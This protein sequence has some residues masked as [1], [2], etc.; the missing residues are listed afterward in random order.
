MALAETVERQSNAALAFQPGPS[1]V[2]DTVSGAV[3]LIE[4]GG[5][6]ITVDDC[7]GDIYFSDRESGEVLR[8]IRSEDT[9]IVLVGE[10]QDPSQMLATYRSGLPCPDGFQL[11]VLEQSADQ[12]LLITPRQ[13]RVNTWLNADDANDILLLPE[14]TPFSDRET[15]LVAEAV[16]NQ[17]SLT[18][19]D[20][21]DAYEN[22]PDNKP[23]KGCPGKFVLPDRKLE[24]AI[25]AEL[26]LDEAG[27]I[28]CELTAQL[29][30]LNAEDSDI[31]NLKG[32]EFF[33]NLE[34]LFLSNNQ[35]RNLH[36]LSEL[37]RLST[38]DLSNNQIRAIGSLAQLPD[39]ASLDLSG[40]RISDLWPLLLNPG[41]GKDDSIDLGS[42]SLDV[43]DDH[44]VNELSRR[45][46]D[47][48]AECKAQSE[49]AA[50]PG[51]AP[52][53]NDPGNGNGQGN[54][55]GNSGSGRGNGG[56]N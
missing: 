34:S 55:G 28:T 1:A 42:N 30:T 41:L 49:N 14:D 24:E 25:R 56:G 11:L 33:P 39:L 44:Y 15:V 45:G 5:N 37:E 51:R 54:G 48:D 38:L 3:T 43:D 53:G 19:I 50:C 16:E 31:R 29:T 35:I 18:A 22:K 2:S 7:S 12:I 8:W 23:E 20:L 40:N 21:P 6:G 32:L 47:V 46:A 17:G 4:R 26:G 36:P 52:N 9:L 27:P 10:L 13:E